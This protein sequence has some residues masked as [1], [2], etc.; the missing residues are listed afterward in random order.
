ME[1][2]LKN[3][4]SDDIWSALYCAEAL[5]KENITGI[6]KIHGADMVVRTLTSLE[7]LRLDIN[8]A[9]FATE[10]GASADAA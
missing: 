5:I 9:A 4:T 10:H 2:T 1:L 6:C 7:K 8:R 3:W